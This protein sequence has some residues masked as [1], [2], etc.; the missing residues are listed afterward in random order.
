MIYELHTIT[1]H[2]ID[3]EN[4]ADLPE[5]V[6]YVPNPPIPE[7]FWQLAW[8]CILKDTFDFTSSASGFDFYWKGE[9][10]I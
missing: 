7:H 9:C 6:D 10:W 3:F 4:D 8:T 1:Q 5:T 2:L